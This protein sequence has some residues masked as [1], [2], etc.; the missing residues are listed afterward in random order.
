MVKEATFGAGCFW[1]IEACFKDIQGVVDVNLGYAGGDAS[2][3]NYK[4]VCTGDTGHV[5]VAKISFDTELVDYR[6]LLEM[7]WFVHDPTQLNRQGNDVGTQYRSAIFY[8]DKEQRALAEESK[9]LLSESGA[10]S[11]P[12]VTEI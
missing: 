12:I 7:F 3:A 8:H 6:R 4:A 2:T 11:D 5:E 10:W 1:C 9:R